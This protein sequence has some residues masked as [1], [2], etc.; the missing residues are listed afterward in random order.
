M[1]FRLVSF[2]ILKWVFN[3]LTLPRSIYRHNRGD[4]IQEE[5]VGE[6]AALK[7]YLTAKLKTL[8]LLCRGMDIVIL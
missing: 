3:I 7:T 8:S 5:C 4:I 1:A 6:F 2:L